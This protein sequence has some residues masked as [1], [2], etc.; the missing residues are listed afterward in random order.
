MNDIVLGVS[1]RGNPSMQ[2][3]Q[4]YKRVTGD[5]IECHLY[6]LYRAL[7]TPVHRQ[8]RD[9][10]NNDL[11]ERTRSIFSFHLKYSS[12]IV[13]SELIHFKLLRV[14]ELRHREIDNFPVQILSL[15]WL[16]YLSL[17]CSRNLNIP[18]EICRLWSLQTFI[19][20]G[21]NGSVITITFPEEIWGLMQLRHLKLPEFYLP[22]P[23][24]VSA[25]KGSHMAFSNIQTFSYLHPRCCTNEVIMGI[26]NVKEIG[27]FGNEI[28][29]NGLLNSLVHLQQLETLSLIYCFSRFL[30]A[31]AKAFPATLKKL[32]LKRNFLR[33]SY[34]DIIAELPNLEVLKVMF[35]ACRGEEWHPNVTG[36]TRLKVLLIE[37]CFLMYWKA[38]DD[39]FPV[40]ERLV[41][42]KCT[43]LKEIPIEFAEIHTLQLIELRSCL[44]EL[45]ESAAQIQQEQE[46]LGNNPMD[47]RISDDT[48]RL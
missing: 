26:Q 12:F 10:D 4:P 41:L 45:G 9:H 36:F 23:P 33:W 18:P 15:I 16:R 5:K 13:K 14:L 37:D 46:D 24:S 42:K 47:V 17:Q 25:D 22:N 34:M 32:K 35:H 48:S 6:G 43:Y 44:P 19:V 29:S 11:L 28:R 38:T 31:S 8:L 7:L 39:N 40:L 21:L 3:M 1:E 27:I 30:P 2:K 20:Q